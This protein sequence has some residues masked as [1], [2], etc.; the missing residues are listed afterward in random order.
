APVSTPLAV[1]LVNPDQGEWTVPGAITINPKP[2]FSSIQYEGSLTSIG[3]G[4]TGSTLTIW[5]AN[6]VDG[7][8]IDFGLGVTEKTYEFITST[9]IRLTLDV[10]A[11]ATVGQRNVTVT[12]PDLGYATKVNALNITHSPDVDYLDPASRTYN[13]TGAT[14]TVYASGA[15]FQTTGGDTEVEFSTNPSASWFKDEAISGTAVVLTASELELRNVSIANGALTG[16]RYIRVLNP[17]G[18]LHTSIT[19]K[20]TV[21][22]DMSLDAGGLT[23]LGSQTK[24]ELGQNTADKVL[25]ILGSGFES[26]IGVDN[27][28]FGAK[29]S[30]I[31]VES[32][33]WKSGT[34]IEVTVSVSTHCL[35]GKTTVQIENPVNGGIVS[36]GDP[37]YFMIIEAPRISTVTSPTVKEYGQRANT[38]GYADKKFKLQGLGFNIDMGLYVGGTQ[39]TISNQELTASATEFWCDLIIPETFSTGLKDIQVINPDQGEWTLSNAI[40][41][42]PKPTFTSVSYGAGQTAVG[43]GG[44]GLTVIVNG[45]GLQDGSYAD[46]GVGITTQT[47]NYH[48]GGG[49]ITYTV[50]VDAYATVGKRDVTV[51]NPDLGYATKASGLEVT[52]SPDVS[53]ISPDVRAQGMTG[54]TI[55]VY[56]S[57]AYF[58][59]GCEVWFSTSSDGEPA[60]PKVGTGTIYMSGSPASTL[61]LQNT[62]IAADAPV[63]DYYIGT[64]NR[65][66][67]KAVSLAS[68]LEIKAGATLTEDG[69]TVVGSATGYE[70]QLGQNTSDKTLK[71]TGTNFESGIGAAN[72]SFGVKDSSI[73]VQSVSWKS[74]GLIEAL[75]NISTNCLT[76]NTTVWVTN[77]ES[78]SI[79]KSDG[80]ADYF[81]IGRWPEISTITS[82]SDYQYGQ[83][84]NTAGYGDKK[85]KLSG[86]GFNEAMEL[87]F[88]D[89]KM[90]PVSPAVD[91]AVVGDTQTYSCDLNIS[92]TFS[93]L[94]W[95]AVRVVNPDQGEYTRAS[96]IKINARPTITALT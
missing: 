75:V 7:A 32:V 84:A 57:G 78:G 53:F 54:S 9:A 58:R 18:G 42:N 24:Y 81:I 76:G 21:T 93:P 59:T 95:Q 2:T 16:G 5:G 55:T 29:T 79:A 41:I 12:N 40:T 27:V 14:L 94:G 61:E 87:W 71:L 17:D 50:D 23:V 85:F 74:G 90:T 62:T 36:R 89:T 26:G 22:A 48:I 44:E 72:V 77:P 10:D 70:K 66:G 31:T 47:Y 82:P 11:A 91:N 25:S 39:L 30:S 3:Q 86:R 15:Y 35:T 69:L 34:R 38:E 37:N 92:E 60:E 4:A 6:L 20:F 8:E 63:G 46:F 51:W 1:K 19:T 68:V 33:S 96:T 13:I 49:S 65:D 45:S 43:Q 73:T 80:Y 28:S 88:G 56:G 67:G 64:R 52:H 83:T